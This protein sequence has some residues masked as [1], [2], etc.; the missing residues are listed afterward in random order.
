MS[1]GFSGWLFVLLPVRGFGQSLDEGLCGCAAVHVAA[2]VRAPRI[3]ADEEVVENGLHLL[4][5][6]EP[7]AASLDAVVLVEHRVVEALYDAVGL[8]TLGAALRS[9][10]SPN[11]RMSS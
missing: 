4:D 3:V 11:C 6:F 7:G 2:L 9:S 5:S 1:G 8:G 10:I